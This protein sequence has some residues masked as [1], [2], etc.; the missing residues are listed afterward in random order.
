[1]PRERVQEVV[2]D[3]VKRGRMTRARRQ[4]AGLEPRQPQPQGD[5]RP[6]PRPREAARAGAQGGRD[7][8]PGAQTDRASRRPAPPGASG[9]RPATPPTGRWPRPTSSAAAPAPPARPITGYE[10]LTAAQVKS[11]L[12]D[13]NPADLRKVRDPGEARQGA[14][15]R[16]RL[17]RQAARQV[18]DALADGGQLGDQ[19]AEVEL[20]RRAPRRAARRRGSRWPSRHS[21]RSHSPASGCGEPA[22]AEALAQARGASASRAP[23]RAGSRRRRSPGSTSA[24]HG[25]A[26]ASATRVAP[27]SSSA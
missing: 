3:A 12:K 14:Q 17:D 7:E 5:R 23:R 25:L 27:P 2:D 9:A 13:L 4:R 15:E 19:R 11:R 1:M 16:P 8:P 24:S 21:P 18:A 20:A 6:D 26:A 22:L 10:Q